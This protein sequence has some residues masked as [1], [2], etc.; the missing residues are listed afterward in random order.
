M[1]KYCDAINTRT[2]QYQ[3]TQSK[4]ETDICLFFSVKISHFHRISA[5][6]KAPKSLK[7]KELSVTYPVYILFIFFFFKRFRINNVAKFYT[8]FDLLLSGTKVLVPSKLLILKHLCLLTSFGACLILG[9]YPYAPKV[10]I[11]KH[12]RHIFPAKNRRNQRILPAKKGKFKMRLSMS[13]E[14]DMARNIDKELKILHQAHWAI[15]VNPTLT[16]AEWEGLR[17]LSRIQEY[18]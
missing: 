9:G 3:S 8:S 11:F 13:H 6:K 12:L 5:G 15:G 18:R 2:N 1:S 16:D 7:R 14:C 10:F 17:I 4:T